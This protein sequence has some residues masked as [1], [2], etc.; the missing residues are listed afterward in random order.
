MAK[1]TFMSEGRAERISLETARK[2]KGGEN[3]NL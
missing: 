1:V 2:G 3:F